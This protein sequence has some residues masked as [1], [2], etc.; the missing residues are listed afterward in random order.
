MAYPKL[1]LIIVSSLIK[2]IL[3]S[4]SLMN[5]SPGQEVKRALLIWLH[6]GMLK[7]VILSKRKIS[8]ISWNSHLHNLRLGLS[9]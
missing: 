2:R 4:M 5:G 1:L 6:S 3:S 7:D 8:Y 9:T